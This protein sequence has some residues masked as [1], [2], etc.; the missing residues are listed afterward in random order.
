ME[1]KKRT[2]GQNLLLKRETPAQNGS[3][4]MSELF[5][6]Y[7]VCR[8]VLPIWARRPDIL[9]IDNLYE[10]LKFKSLKLPNKQ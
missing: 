9:K 3:V 6:K 1:N 7:L 5:R 8:V 2:G 10:K 4:G